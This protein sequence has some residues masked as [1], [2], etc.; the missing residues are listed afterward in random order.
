MGMTNRLHGKMVPLP[1]GKGVNCPHCLAE[2][3]KYDLFVKDGKAIKICPFCE[4]EL[5]KK[6]AEKLD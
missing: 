5:P 6:I 1:S 4:R 2:L 3:S